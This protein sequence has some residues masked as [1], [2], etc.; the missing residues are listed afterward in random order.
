MN[1]QKIGK[2][3]LLRALFDL[4]ATLGLLNEYTIIPFY[5]PMNETWS[6]KTLRF[7]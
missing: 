1:W 7:W 4:F 5:G 6:D 3:T 2:M